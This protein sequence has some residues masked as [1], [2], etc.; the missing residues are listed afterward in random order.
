[1]LPEMLNV[2]MLVWGL[3]EPKCRHLFWWICWIYVSFKFILRATGGESC[4]LMKYKTNHQKMQLGKYFWSHLN[5]P[6][7]YTREVCQPK[8]YFF[9]KLVVKIVKHHSDY[10]F[11]LIT[12]QHGCTS[13]QK[14]HFK[15]VKYHNKSGHDR[16]SCEVSVNLTVEHIFSLR[17]DKCISTQMWSK[18][19][20]VV[21]VLK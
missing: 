6:I 17:L 19:D 5:C 21:N 3:Q 12:H 20:S 16:T 4:C 8:R 13:E 10:F 15:K 14:K 2:D 9:L 18:D 1:M 11:S 7:N